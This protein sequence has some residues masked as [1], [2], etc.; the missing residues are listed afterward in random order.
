MVAV[1]TLWTDPKCIPRSGG[2]PPFLQALDVDV[3]R[4]GGERRGGGKYGLGLMVFRGN[5]YTNG[6]FAKTRSDQS[7]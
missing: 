1:M 5:T 4:E 7:A 6:A 2:G 3:L